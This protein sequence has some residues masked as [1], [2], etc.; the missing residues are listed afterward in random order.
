MNWVVRRNSCTIL[1]THFG[2]GFTTG[3]GSQY[4]LNPVTKQR[5]AMVSELTDGWFAPTG[6]VLDR[7]SA[8]QQIAF[9]PFAGGLVAS[10]QSGEDVGRITFIGE[11][12]RVYRSSNGCQIE[13]DATGVFVLPMLAKGEVCFIGEQGPAEES[14]T[15]TG[16]NKPMLAADLHTAVQKVLHRF[17]A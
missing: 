4:Q 8:F 6:E 10:N 2:K 5:L 3:S 9:Q 15:W 1:Y 16:F 17:G 7:L 11:P 13:A 12:K 14:K